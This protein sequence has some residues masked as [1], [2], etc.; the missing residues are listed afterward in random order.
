MSVALTE[1]TEVVIIE[2]GLQSKEPQTSEDVKQPSLNQQ[3]DKLLIEAIDEAMTSLG[4][5]VKNEFYLK[6][7]INFN[8]EKEAIPERLEEFSGILHKIFGLGA[9]R[10]ETKFLKNL[11]SKTFCEKKCDYNVSVWIEREMSLVK[12]VADKK[13]DFILKSE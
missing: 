1:E 13:Q 8:M 7:E 10:L 9:C 12:S 2:A 5:P 6:L 11:D 3:F 4:I